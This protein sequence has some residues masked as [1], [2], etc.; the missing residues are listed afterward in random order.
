MTEYAHFVGRIGGLAAALGV[1][2]ALT[3]GPAVVYADTGN[4]SSPTNNSSTNTSSQSETSAT[5]Q[6]A[7][8]TSA[9][10]ESSPTT[11]S[12]NTS[13]H[14][15]ASGTKKPA[16]TTATPRHL[17][18]SA[19]PTAGTADIPSGATELPSSATTT[20]PEADPSSDV[21]Q[22][23]ATETTE[24]VSAPTTPTD[25]PPPPGDATATPSAVTV[26]DP[27][28]SATTD[29]NP[30]G[31]SKPTAAPLI[32][33]TAKPV[34]A[35]I[36]QSTARTTAA[37]S[38]LSA[39]PTTPLGA[40]NVGSKNTALT[41][42]QAGAQIAALAPAA[43]TSTPPPTLISTVVTTVDRLLR[44]I[45]T[46]AMDLTGSGAPLDNPLAWAILAWTRRT[47]FNDANNTATLVAATSTATAVTDKDF[48]VSFSSPNTS[49]AV[50]VTIIAD[51][52]FGP[53]TYSVLNAPKPATGTVTTESTPGVFTYT[54]TTPA[55]VSA[56]TGGPNTDK[57]II[58][59]APTSNP[60]EVLAT[61]EITAPVQPAAFSLKVMPV[62]GMTDTVVSK[63]TAKLDTDLDLAGIPVAYRVD[64]K[65]QPKYGK[66][67]IDPETGEWA[68][69]PNIEAVVNANIDSG[70]F[71]DGFVDKTTDIDDLPDP[72]PNSF[73]TP[74]KITLDTGNWW[75]WDSGKSDWV[76]DV[77]G[78]PRFDTFTISAY[79][80]NNSSTIYDS[81]P[82]HTDFARLTFHLAI[83]QDQDAVYVFPKGYQWNYVTAP[84]DDSGKVIDSSGS[85][86]NIDPKTGRL[87]YIPNATLTASG[88]TEK[89]SI[90]ATADGTDHPTITCRP[91]DYCGGGA[92]FNVPEDGTGT[93]TVTL[94][95]NSGLSDAVAD[96]AFVGSST[97]GPVGPGASG[98]KIG[99]GSTAPGGTPGGGIPGGIPGGDSGGGTIPSV[100]PRSVGTPSRPASPVVALLPTTGDAGTPTNQPLPQAAAPPIQCDP[101]LPYCVPLDTQAQ[102][103]PFDV[104][105]WLDIVLG[106][107]LLNNLPG[108]TDPTAPAPIPF[109]PLDTHAQGQPLDIIAWLD[110]FL[111]VNFPDTVPAP[112][113]ANAPAN[114]SIAPLSAPAPTPGTP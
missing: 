51:D 71:F 84:I 9:R 89:F 62:N 112:T 68:Y 98:Y 93:W 54:P 75:Q 19:T 79:D 82:I 83:T 27:P 77:G 111:G 110:T 14:S 92:V 31:D 7:G 15:R 4:E 87:T 33:V 25:T 28:P 6:Q 10:S 70:V 95:K 85:V 8:T 32:Q 73:G 26:T 86:F 45:V 114:T 22:E 67:N 104:I 12:T 41:T 58:K 102:A 63:G 109:A 90:T 40:T 35:P 94:S 49:G 100:P 1:G 44:N 36:L 113:D 76:E 61:V 59:I 48:K 23:P 101:D 65:N 30:A 96:Q 69:T 78:R 50:T 13:R 103:Q 97:R 43:T 81:V 108:P 21:D 107:D 64:E 38:P 37:L 3:A 74:A 56:A 80:P 57:F 39:N 88:G 66:V 11:K 17:D 72:D 52:R 99:T 55:R 106:L 18:S 24:S 20:A 5:N 105:A 53:V 46:A 34:T 91:A 2:I 29:T 42:N 60:T 16:D 47:F